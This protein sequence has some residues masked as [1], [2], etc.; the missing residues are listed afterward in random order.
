MKY[1]F[2]IGSFLSWLMIISGILFFLPQLILAGLI[3]FGITAL[4]CF[5]MDGMN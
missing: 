1:I 4:V 5:T 3:S 2:F